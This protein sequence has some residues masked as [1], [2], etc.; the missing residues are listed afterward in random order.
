MYI[1]YDKRSCFVES[2]HSKYRSAF[3][4]RSKIVDKLRKI[5]RGYEKD[6]AIMWEGEAGVIRDLTEQEWGNLRILHG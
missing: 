4:A 2:R 3:K 6:F 5:S 1:I